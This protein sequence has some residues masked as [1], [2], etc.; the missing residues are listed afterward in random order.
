[1]SYSKEYIIELIEI[2]ELF[3]NDET[4]KLSHKL[5][6]EFVEKHKIFYNQ[7]KGDYILYKGKQDFSLT[8]NCINWDSFCVNNRSH[9]S[10]QPSLLNIIKETRIISVIET[11]KFYEL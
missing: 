2:L 7:K 6:K 8:F 1:M 11:I 9:H 5:I 4:I 3:N 10:F